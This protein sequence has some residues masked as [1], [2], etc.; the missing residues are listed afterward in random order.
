MKAA[1]DSGLSERAFA[2][3]WVLREDDAVKAAGLDAMV[4]AREAE[5]LLARFPNASLNPDEQ[6]RLRAA[7]YIPVLAL[8]PKERTR[9]VDLMIQRLLDEAET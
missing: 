3:Y 2:V 4:L 1:R 6:R 9:V 5:A 7:I 8:E